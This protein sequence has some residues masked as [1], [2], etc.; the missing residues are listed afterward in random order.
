LKEQ[1]P[2]SKRRYRAIFEQAILA[3]FFH[4]ENG[5]PV[6][7][8][9]WTFVIHQ[10]YRKKAGIEADAMDVNGVKAVLIFVVAGVMMIGKG[11][12]Q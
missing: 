11:T 8:E 1:S 5:E 9:E 4:H 10:L 6:M 12:R 7:P 2:T 3:M